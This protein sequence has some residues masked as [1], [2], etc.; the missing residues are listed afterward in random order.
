MQIRKLIDG[1]SSG[2][3]KVG[4]AI[5][6]TL[7]VSVGVANAAVILLGCGVLATSG[8]VVGSMM[9]NQNNYTQI[10]V[11]DDECVDYIQQAK[12]E[13][14]TGEVQIPEYTGPERFLT[15]TVGT[16][17]FTAEF[18]ESK[19]A[20]GEYSGEVYGPTVRLWRSHGAKR[21]EYGFDR[22]GDLYIGA[23]TPKLCPYMGNSEV[24][25]G[26]VLTFYFDDGT[27]I[28][29]LVA[30]HKASS[31][32]DPNGAAVPDG[33][34]SSVSV[35]Y[36]GHITGGNCAV[37]EFWGDSR[38][39]SS[40][41]PLRAST[42]GSFNRVVSVT[43]L[44]M[45]AEWVREANQ[46]GSL[47]EAASVSLNDIRSSKSKSVM[48]ECKQ[49]ANFDNST[50][51]AAAASYSYSQRKTFGEGYPGTQ[52]YHSV[53]TATIH[54]EYYRSCDRGV[55]AAVKWCGADKEFHYGGCADQYSYMAQSPL[56]E[57][58]SSSSPDKTVKNR[59]AGALNHSFGGSAAD[60]AEWATEHL[61]PGDILC[62]EANEH[63]FMYIGSDIA[64]QVYQQS[65][66]G[67]KAPSGGD[68]GTPDSNAVFMSASIGMTMPSTPDSGP[69]SGRAPCIQPV[70]GDGRTY[71]AFRYVGDYPDKDE[72]AD[73]GSDIAIVGSTS[74]DTSC[75][76][77]EE[78]DSCEECNDQADELEYIQND[79]NGNGG[80]E[81][82]A[83][84]ADMFGGQIDCTFCAYVAAANIAAC[85]YS[86]TPVSVAAGLQAKYGEDF[87]YGAAPGGGVIPGVTQVRYD[88][89]K[90]GD[91]LDEISGTTRHTV[92]KADCSVDS[93]ANYL[94]NGSTIVMHGGK[95]IS[96]VKED[97]HSRVHANGHSAMLYK[98]DGM[99]FWGK[100]STT[101]DGSGHIR[102][103]RSQVA[104]FIASEPFYSVTVFD[105]E[106]K[107]TG[108][109]D[110][111]DMLSDGPISKTQQDVITSAMSTPTPGPK[112][113]AQ[114]VTNVFVGA[115]I[116]GDIGGDACDMYNKWCTSS[117]KSD[118]KPG[119]IVAVNTHNLTS[120]GLVYGHV[121][122]YIGNGMVRHNVGEI[123]D[124]PLETWIRTY[125]TTVPVK[126]GWLGGIDLSK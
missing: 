122:I 106:G 13:M 70:G 75:E 99:Y 102:W 87:R 90:V 86:F 44:G 101:S 24:N 26:D 14:G 76:C 88:L 7:G 11:D 67:N 123:E 19:I 31:V 100:D 48:D 34:D 93:W 72:Y 51:A 85:D 42:G 54:D 50:I 37:L 56:W 32:T 20:A 29:Y 64:N 30:D 60:C 116:A 96:Y 3:T 69:D 17:E 6:S 40:M 121:G 71:Y 33:V 74:A 107:G 92:Y 120:A 28:N 10:W 68:C 105:G 25:V 63:I 38:I 83:G 36:W 103:T 58:V 110:T 73:V 18:C 35:N 1:V 124:M 91:Y 52:L 5:A 59:E 2:V 45:L 81:L 21:D 66:Q 22:I 80:N 79:Y 94:S 4:G 108:C 89:G 84:A 43:N 47:L 57:F 53:W 16:R 111:S 9:T 23:V 65:I 62:T 77:M 8:V 49:A 109:K 98:Y 117:K 55:A 104:D 95:G 82:A 39:D 41:A 114:W 15:G 115:G 46:A 78:D 97:G 125:G 126:W 113:C 27:S 118:L 12:D 119:M 112:L 61:Q